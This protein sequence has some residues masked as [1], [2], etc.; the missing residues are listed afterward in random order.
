MDKILSNDISNWYDPVKN[1]KPS[2]F[3]ENIFAPLSYFSAIDTSIHVVCH[4]ESVICMYNWQR[5]QATK[6]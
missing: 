1:M 2:S 4:N 5:K 3:L 6:L